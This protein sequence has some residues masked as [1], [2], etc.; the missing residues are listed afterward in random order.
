MLRACLA[1]TALVASLATTAYAHPN[2]DYEG[3]CGFS[4]VND[5][6]PGGIFGGPTYWRGEISTYA[7]AFTADHLPAPTTQISIACELYI[8][9]T[10]VD[11]PLTASGN[12]VVAAAG[13]FS[14]TAEDTDVIQICNHVVVGGEDHYTNCWDGGHGLPELYEVAQ[15]LI[16]QVI[17][18]I[19]QIDPLVCTQFSALAPGIPGVV[20]IQPEGDIAVLGEPFWDCPPYDV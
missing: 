18:I 1:A 11:T 6:T 10:L 20:D 3:D 7:V 16:D 9:G 13:T 14:F 5:T 4:T 2:Y 8:N 19:D 15:F 12:G 17:P